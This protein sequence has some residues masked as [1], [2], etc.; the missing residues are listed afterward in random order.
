MAAVPLY[1]SAGAAQ[2]AGT[3]SKFTPAADA[4]VD[5]SQAKVNF[6][7][8]AALRTDSS[9]VVHSY[10]RFGVANLAGEV[11]RATL[12]ILPKVSSA[13][14]VSVRPVSGNWG[15]KTITWANAPAPGTA[16]AS[17]GAL[18][19]G[20]WAS[21]DVTSLVAGN[22][23]VNLAL[24]APA[25][26]AVGLPSREASSNRPQLVVETGGGTTT[27]T[28][29]P[30]TTT[31]TA[32]PT[33]TTTVPPTTTTTV[34]PTTTT[35]VPTTTTTVPTTTTTTAPSGGGTLPTGC[36]A[37]LSVR[38]ATANVLGYLFGDGHWGTSGYNYDARDSCKLARMKNDLNTIGV[39]Y[40]L[41][42][43]HFTIAAVAPFDKPQDFGVSPWMATASGDEIKAFL[44]GLLEGEGSGSGKVFDDPGWGRTS[45][46]VDTYQRINVVVKPDHPAPTCGCE[47]DGT[48]W[49]TY[50]DP[51]APTSVYNGYIAII[52]SFPFAET[53]R[54]PNYR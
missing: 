38:L 41:S 54:V 44:A 49:N 47:T 40:T 17:S 19:A 21:I 39:R 3:V 32:P 10:L 23:A 16:V 11:S 48:Y 1:L 37:G 2:S 26:G 36:N 53:N 6:G 35:T 27:T 42:T 34:P 14:G 7:T 50:V 8:K 5:Q 29:V 46:V 33:T 45:G 22:G 24:V 12:R 30:P 18:T 15:E 13:A 31:T 25:G 43:S 9:P 20:T 52:K 51:S 4:F 28:T